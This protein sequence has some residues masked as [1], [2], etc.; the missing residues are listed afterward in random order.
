MA[1]KQSGAKLINQT[2][3]LSQ[4]ESHL[5]ESANILRGPVDAADL[6]TDIFPLLFFKRICDLWDE[7]YAEIVE[8]TGDAE[9]ALFPE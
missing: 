2:I 7:E 5:L 8:E 1:K 6:K 3:T 4:L 9:L